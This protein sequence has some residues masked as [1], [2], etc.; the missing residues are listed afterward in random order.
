M[1]FQQH[2][3]LS[4]YVRPTIWR[5]GKCARRRAPVR[6]LLVRWAWRPQVLQPARLGRLGACALHPMLRRRRQGW[7]R[8][9]FRPFAPRV[10]AQAGG[11]TRTSLRGAQSFR[12]GLAFDWWTLRVTWVSDWAHFSVRD[13]YW[14]FL[15]HFD[16]RVQTWTRCT[17]LFFKVFWLV[18][19]FLYHRLRVN[20]DFFALSV[21]IGCFTKW[22]QLFQFQTKNFHSQHNRQ[23]YLPIWLFLTAICCVT[24][25]SCDYLRP[26]P[27]FLHHSLTISVSRS[28]FVND[29]SSITLSFL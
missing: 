3:Q 28:H 24:I 7:W 9:G 15:C 20:D 27:A 16:G 21:D 14:I 23:L 10:V 6:L 13:V 29:N 11:G 19:C 5:F 8:R 17:S 26:I 12:C 4:R 1:N 22:T 18:K 25:P 2:L